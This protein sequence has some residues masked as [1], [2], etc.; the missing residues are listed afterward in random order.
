MKYTDSY[1]IAYQKI[2]KSNKEHQNR[3]SYLIKFFESDVTE[4]LKVSPDGFCHALEVGCG[5]GS[6]F[7]YLKEPAFKAKGIDISESAI[8]MAKSKSSKTEYECLDVT[9][10]K[11]ENQYD[12]VVDG[13]CLHCL[14]D[15]NE[16]QDAL[17]NIYRALKPGGLYVLETMTDHKRMEF[18]EHLY[19]DKNNK[20]LYRHTTNALYEDLMFHEG[21]PFLPIRRIKHSMEIENEILGIGFKIIFLYIFSNL[22]VI[23]DESRTHPLISDPELL[24]MIAVKE[25]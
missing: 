12:L 21:K 10:L 24:R 17:K 4:R 9:K 3:P 23:P 16:R 19:F 14:V 20:T 1:E 2:L 11:D 7:D 22:K 8:E 15:E 5:T 25:T 18:E 13:H 6:V